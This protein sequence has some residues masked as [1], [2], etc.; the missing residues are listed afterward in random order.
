M[1][2]LGFGFYQFFI[3]DTRVFLFYFLHLLLAMCKSNGNIKM[4]ARCIPM[5]LDCN[6]NV[7]MKINLLWQRNKW[8]NILNLF[9]WHATKRMVKKMNLNAENIHLHH[10]CC[11]VRFFNGSW[12]LAACQRWHRTYCQNVL[13]TRFHSDHLTVNSINLLIFVLRNDLIFGSEIE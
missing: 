3:R 12:F 2:K 8:K 5:S 11:A 4:S 13:W 6:K 9:N 1:F 10:G 7:C